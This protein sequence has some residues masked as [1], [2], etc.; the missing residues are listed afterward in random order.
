MK[1]VKGKITNDTNILTLHKKECVKDCPWVRDEN[2]PGRFLSGTIF[3][4]G[5][6]KHRLA[7]ARTKCSSR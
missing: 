7:K 1:P 3:S 6:R 5:C 4:P 2:Y